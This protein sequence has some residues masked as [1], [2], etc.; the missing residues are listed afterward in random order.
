MK[1]N[2]EHALQYRHTQRRGDKA[3]IAMV[4][5]FFASW[6]LLSKLDPAVIFH[7]APWSVAIPVALAVYFLTF[8]LLPKQQSA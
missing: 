5:A 3:G 6:F 8:W 7:Q 1:T 2:R 4:V